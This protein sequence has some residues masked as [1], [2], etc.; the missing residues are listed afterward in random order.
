MTYPST[1][2]AHATM[3]VRRAGES[4]APVGF[5]WAGVT[6]TA[7]APDPR[8]LSTTTAVRVDRDAAVTEP[9]GREH[10]AG[11]VVAGIL[12]GD[13]RVPAVAQHAHDQ[14]EAVAEPVADHDLVGVGAH[15][16]HP[17]EVVGHG[18]A[19]L[20]QP[21][22]VAVA[23][24]VTRQAS[25]VRRASPGATPLAGTGR[26]RAGRAGS[27]PRPARCRVPSGR[28]GPLLARWR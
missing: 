5:W 14:A 4:T 22:R 25:A 2:R 26:G 24:V 27:P 21:L 13:Q 8:S 1:A 16:P 15:P 18:L 6:T 17:C 3:A 19:Q 10:L 23:E 11:A 20:R 9:G 12:D 28:G 7:R